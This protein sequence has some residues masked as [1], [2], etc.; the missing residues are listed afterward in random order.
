MNTLVIV[1]SNC[2]SDQGSTCSV[3]SQF[4]G[5]DYMLTKSIDSNTGLEEHTF[6]GFLQLQYTNAYTHNF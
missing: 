6:S 4:I 2:I 5:L 1:L 3:A